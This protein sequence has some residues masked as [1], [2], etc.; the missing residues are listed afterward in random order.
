[1]ADPF[2]VKLPKYF[3]LCFSSCSTLVPMQVHDYPQWLGLAFANC[4][5]Q[6]DPWVMK[7]PIEGEKKLKAVSSSNSLDFNECNNCRS[8]WPAGIFPVD[9]SVYTVFAA[10]CVIIKKL[11]P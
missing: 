3:G 10:L 9:M 8:K 11:L 7:F 4:G 6:S 2:S 1:M 5:S